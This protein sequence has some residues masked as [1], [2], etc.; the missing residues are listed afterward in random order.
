MQQILCVFWAEICGNLGPESSISVSKVQ[1]QGT[2]IQ[3]CRHTDYCRR[4]NIFLYFLG[5]NVYQLL[6]LV[7]EYQMTKV[8]Q[9]C[10]KYLLSQQPSVKSLVL[11]DKFKL[12]KY[13]PLLR[14]VR[15]SIKIE[16]K[17]PLE[18]SEN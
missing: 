8:T 12:L 3:K 15:R 14:F 4:P 6:P 13:V 11:A 9:R 7:E 2:A 5:S 10:E 18:P 1:A 17:Y 16:Y